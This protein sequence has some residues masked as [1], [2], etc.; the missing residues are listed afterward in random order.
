M[1]E[2][3]IREIAP[4]LKENEDIQKQLSDSNGIEISIDISKDEF[5]TEAETLPWQKGV[6]A[7]R[8]LR[9]MCFLGDKPI[10]NSTLF[11]MLGLSKKDFDNSRIFNRNFPISVGRNNGENKWNL[12][13]KY[14]KSPT[15][16]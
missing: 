8:K 16:V 10:K 11:D 6:K 9:D 2:N 7:A 3:S 12:L 13:P 15:G 14:R 5:E 4:L 1:G